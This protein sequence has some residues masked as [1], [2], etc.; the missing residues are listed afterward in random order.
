MG[1]KDVLK[2]FLEGR[3]IFVTDIRMRG[4]I[5]LMCSIKDYKVINDKVV[6]VTFADGT[7]EKAV[8]SPKDAFDL[9]RAIEICIC[10]KVFGGTKA[11][12]N[13]I[14]DALK[15]VAAIDKQKKADKE[16]AERIAK[17][18]AKEIERKILR[19]EKKRQ[20]QVDIQAEAFLKAMQMYDEQV[21][22]VENVEEIK[23]N[24]VIETTE[25]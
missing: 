19:R 22:D 23:K 2:M 7:T 14:K 12:N 5:K 10:K 13:A 21:G 20:E 3:T 9:E 6:I 16:K 18:K 24:D 25:N 15:D 17:K 1:D 8:C 4:A 11:Y